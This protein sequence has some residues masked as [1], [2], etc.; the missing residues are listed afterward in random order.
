MVIAPEINYFFGKS[1]KSTEHRVKCGI[2]V[3]TD[4]ATN[5]TFDGLSRLHPLV[6]DLPQ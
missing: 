3:K 6:S 4:T 1:S 2:S 5:K